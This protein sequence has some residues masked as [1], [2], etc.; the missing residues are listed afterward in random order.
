[1]LGGGTDVVSGELLCAAVFVLAGVTLARR[2]T[3]SL[4]GVRFTAEFEELA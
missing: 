2:G 3:E 4:V 1:M